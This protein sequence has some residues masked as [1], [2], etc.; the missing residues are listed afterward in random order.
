MSRTEIGELGIITV[1]TLTV[2]TLF[3]IPIWWI[4]NGLFKREATLREKLWKQL[5]H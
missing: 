1:L 4:R 2:V 5:F 3:C